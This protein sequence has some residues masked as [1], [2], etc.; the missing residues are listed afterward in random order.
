MAEHMGTDNSSTILDWLESLSTHT[1]CSLL[2]LDGVRGPAG[3]PELSQSF[4]IYS[5]PIYSSPIYSS[6]IY[7]SPI[8]SSPISH[9]RHPVLCTTPRMTCNYP[10]HEPMYFNG[11]E[12]PVSFHASQTRAL[13]AESPPYKT[14]LQPA[15]LRF[16]ELD[17]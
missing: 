16:L 4:P 6:P 9:T 14:Q 1:S 12:T 10:E 8:Y 11:G 13:S 15:R 3:P 17:E 7:S 2:N 5:S